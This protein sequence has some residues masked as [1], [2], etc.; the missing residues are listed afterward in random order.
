MS[1]D[2]TRPREPTYTLFV[3]QGISREETVD[4]VVEEFDVAPVTAADDLREMDDWVNDLIQADS[5]GEFRPG[6]PRI[7][8]KLNRFDLCPLRADMILWIR[9]RPTTLE[10]PR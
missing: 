5:T 6:A 9:R 3:I 10:T 4:R 7:P 2:V 1:K 8:V